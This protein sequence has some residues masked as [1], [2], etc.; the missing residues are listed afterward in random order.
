MK[1]KLVIK[2]IFALIGVVLLIVLVD[3][4]IPAAVLKWLL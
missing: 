1:N 2:G 3:I 4:L